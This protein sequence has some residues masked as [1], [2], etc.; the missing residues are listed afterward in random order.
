M[1]LELVS[2]VQKTFGVSETVFQ[3]ALELSPGSQ[4]SISGAISEIL[5]KRHLESRGF[6]TLRIKEKPGGGNDAKNAEARGDFYFRPKG[7]T[8]DEWWVIESKGLKSNS[9]F[10][11]G[12]LDSPSKVFNFLKGRLFDPERTKKSTYASGLDRYMKE[13]A[14]WEAGHRGKTFPSFNWD[15]NF[16]GAESF[17]LS[18][19]WKS[20]GEL[21]TWVESL[22]AERFSEE[23]YRDRCGAITILETHQP[24][25]R[26]APIT[27][28]KQAAPLVSDFNV[29]AVDLFFRTGEHTFAFMNS[30]QIAHSPTSPEH[31][32]QN[33]TIDILVPG[34]KDDP[35]VNA[36][37]YLDIDSLIAQTSPA[38]R[39][40]DK[41]QLDNRTL[42]DE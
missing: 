11:G 9:E 32:Y 4:G 34:I 41:T 38:P 22:P 39:P 17:D 33:Y 3:N 19:I 5:L 37:W 21:E 15:K 16:P 10:R 36:P 26:E 35:K 6:E 28:K 31:L 8:K 40:L 18:G 20:I 24:S 25:Q 27:G 14:K 7:S 29:M 12:K 13:K 42:N 30:C 23:S 2:Y 1:S